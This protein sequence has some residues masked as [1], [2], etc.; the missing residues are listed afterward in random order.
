M[1]PSDPDDTS[2]PEWARQMPRPGL[3]GAARAR[4]LAAAKAALLPEGENR[5]AFPTARRRWKPGFNT[6]G[7]AACW[8]AILCLN[9]NTPATPHRNYSKPPAMAL[10]PPLDAETTTLLASLYPDRFAKTNAA[11]RSPF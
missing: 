6:T 10:Q 11:F 7:L 8:L 9:W 2:F 5:P 1:N 4:S 3:S